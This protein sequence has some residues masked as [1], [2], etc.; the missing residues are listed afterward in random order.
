[1]TDPSEIRAPSRPDDSVP[2]ERVAKAIARAGLCSRREAEAWIRAGRVAVNG[3]V[4]ESPAVTVTAADAITVDGAPLPGRERTR[5]WLFHKP[6]GVV[7][8]T[9]DAEGRRTVF[10]LLPADMPRVVK[11][12][13][14]DINSEGLLL[15]TND[16]GLA[17]VLE[18]PATGWLR[19]YRV[20]A[21][22][23]ITQEAL[24]R[25]AEGIAVDGVLYGPI[26]ARLEKVQGGNV[27][28]TVGLREGRN[29]E[30]RN[31]LAALGL[32]VNRL[33]RI[34]FGPFALGDLPPGAVTE[35]PRRQLRDQ[36]GPRLTKAAGVDLSGPA[37]PVKRPEPL[38]P[39]PVR[40]RK[41]TARG[42]AQPGRRREWA[43]AGPDA[44]PKGKAGSKRASER[45]PADRGPMPARRESAGTGAADKREGLASRRRGRPRSG[46]PRSGPP[47][48]RS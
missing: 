1:M 26:E 10:D 33:I 12:G 37:P 42:E 18:L 32:A 4:L 39:R 15:L 6:K 25:L 41:A 2:P 7:T 17:R 13:R 34:S 5:L 20:R 9:R 48:R 3:R 45:K 21:F 47:K 11:V 38:P 35:V 29:R 43:D 40:G 14:L 28:L 22:G 16:G 30:V 36:L 27:W 24:D 8:S 23:R 19:K 44:T 46:P 31:V